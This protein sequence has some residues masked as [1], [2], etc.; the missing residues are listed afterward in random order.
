MDNGTEDERFSPNRSYYG[1]YVPRM[2]WTHLENFSSERELV[3]ASLQYDEADYRTTT[4]TRTPSRRRR[5]PAGS[6]VR[7]R[8]RD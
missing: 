1:R 6:S 4:T 8:D 5:R 3:L 7:S 2:T